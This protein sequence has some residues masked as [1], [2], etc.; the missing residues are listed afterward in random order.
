MFTPTYLLLIAGTGVLLGSA[1]ID[2]L[3]VPGH[4][5]RSQESRR[6][7]HSLAPAIFPTGT[8]AAL[9]RFSF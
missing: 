3:S 2:V 1:V 9:G 6:A 4:V 8:I 7:R 5:S